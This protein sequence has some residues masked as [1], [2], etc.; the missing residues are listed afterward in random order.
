MGKVEASQHHLEIN[1]NN[2]GSINSSVA[3]E[4]Y[5]YL[6]IFIFKYKYLMF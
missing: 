1:F 6:F 5:L 3:T 2:I 4:L